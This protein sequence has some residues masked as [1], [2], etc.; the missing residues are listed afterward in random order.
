MVLT[1]PLRSWVV[2]PTYNE[3]PNIARLIPL[4]L[5]Q[6]E[7]FAVLVVDDGSPDGTADIAA[8]LGQRHQGR[9]AVLRRT[10]KEG[11]GRAVLAGWKEAL[12]L[13]AG[14]VYTMDCD[15]SHDPEALPRLELQLVHTDIA[16]G[17]RYV[18]GGRTVNW[19]RR[20]KLLSATANRLARLITGLPVRDCTGGFRGYRRH[21]IEQLARQRVQSAN[22]TFLVETLFLAH[23][24]GFSVGEMPI[25]F[26]ERELGTS[27]VDGRLIVSAIVNLLK[28]GVRRVTTVASPMPA[29]DRS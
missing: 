21:V 3:A 25:V 28:I 17:S 20:R 13:G 22:Y 6:G 23:R 26:K 10:K 14:A 18:P 9:V 29:P 19:P 5:Q 12:R 16:V 11:Y 7:H 15:F 2:V 4:I 27:K 1:P 8:S 24:S